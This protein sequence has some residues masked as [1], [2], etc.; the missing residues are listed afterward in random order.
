[1]TRA[2]ILVVDDNEQN[3]ALA[4]AT[5]QDEGYRVV[6]ANDGEAALRAFEREE[7]DCVLLDVRMPGMDGFEVCRR[8]RSAPWGTH[9]PVLFLTAQRDVDS[10]DAA[11]DAGGDDFLTKPVRP[12]ELIVRV[13]SGIEL[14][15]VSAELREIYDLVRHQRDEL[16]RLGL[17]KERLTSFL[18]HDLK[19]PVNAIDLRAQL[20][21]RDPELSEKAKKSLSSIRD[22]VQSLT[23]LILNL[24][25]I[26]KSGERGLLP[27]LQDVDLSV[28]TQT[29]VEEFA[30]KAQMQDARIETAVEHIALRA[31]P[32]LLRRLLSN[33]VENAVRH[34]PEGSSVRVRAAREAERVRIE[35][36]DDGPG[37][38]EELRLRIFDP[39][40]QVEGNERPSPRVGRGLGLTYCRVA[41]E[42]H[43]GEI[44]AEDGEPGARFVVLLPIA[45]NVPGAESAS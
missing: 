5:L 9:T 10:F 4:E 25:D 38:P 34:A 2:T 41:A 43:G 42:A 1:V 19:N 13:K 21:L 22:E 23:R 26:S 6:L 14:R 8:I 32:D 3:R 40:M 27:R 16:V 35:V 7:P 17:Q 45:P 12:T 24:L 39:F 15:R 36:C 30:P 28:L 29:V 11:I 33:L 44:F 18:V 31:D 37:I 20:L